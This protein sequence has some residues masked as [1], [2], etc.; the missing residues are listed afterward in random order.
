MNSL[1][2][3]SLFPVLV[4]SLIWF[5]PFN[6]IDSANRFLCFVMLC[7]ITAL[8]VIG[9]SVARINVLTSFR[10][11][12]W[13]PTAILSAIPVTVLKLGFRVI[14]PF[15]CRTAGCTV[16]EARK[17]ILIG[18]SLCETRARHLFDEITHGESQNTESIKVD[19]LFPGW[20]SHFS[21]WILMSFWKNILMYFAFFS[22]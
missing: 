3:N 7:S 10:N 1:I 5:F 15:M 18:G 14:T 17:A 4:G 21:N 13:A 8:V 20:I 22:L 6:A 16:Y 9:S 19:C 11:V 2:F 12:T